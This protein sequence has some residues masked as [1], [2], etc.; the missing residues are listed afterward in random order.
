VIG[1]LF[2]GLGR[3]VALVTKLVLTALAMVYL[4][5]ARSFLYVLTAYVAVYFLAGS[6]LVKDVVQDLVSKEIPGFVTTGTIQLGP[7][8]WALSLCDARVH[9]EQS[10]EVMRIELLETEVDWVSMATALPRLLLVPDAPIPM[11]FR[12]VRIVNPMIHVTMDENGDLDIIRAF[13]IPTGEPS[14]P[15]PK[16]IR[17]SHGVLVGGR[18]RVD[19]P[20]V[21]L[22]AEG[23]NLN[24]ANFLLEDI[25]DVT[26]LIPKAQI[27]V[28]DFHMRPHFR[29]FPSLSRLTMPIRN[30]AI[31]RF[32]FVL[33]HFEAMRLT[34]DLDGGTM[35]ASMAM[36]FV[37]GQTPLWKGRV[38]LD[39]PAT[40]S[41]LPELFDGF[42]SGP[43]AAD[44]HGHGSLSEVNL[45]VA[46]R[47]PSMVVG[48]HPVEGV[49]IEASVAPEITPEGR[50]NHP[51][52]LHRFVGEM[53]GGR[54]DVGPFRYVMRWAEPAAP[55]ALGLPMPGLG[56]RH[57]FGGRVVLEGIDPWALLEPLDLTFGLDIAPFLRGSTSGVVHTTGFFDE[58]TGRLSV[59]GSTDKLTLSWAR[60]AGWPLGKEFE[61]SGGFEFSQGGVGAEAPVGSTFED[62]STLTLDEVRVKSGGDAIVVDADFDLKR[63]MVDAY[64]DMRIRDLRRFL[65]HFGVDEVSGRARLAR[66]RVVGSLWDPS[67]ETHATVTG[68]GLGGNPMGT[69]SARLSI[70]EGLLSVGGLRTQAP[71]GSASANGRIRLWGDRIDEPHPTL[72]FTVTDARVDNLQLRNLLPKIGMSARVSVLADRITGEAARL[73]DTIEGAGTV[74]AT[75]VRLGPDSARLV[76]AQLVA[77]ARMLKADN[78]AIT[79]A[80]GDILRGSVMMTKGGRQFSAQLKTESLP[81]TAI[82]WFAA[83][84]VDLEGQVTADLSVD[85]TL[86]DPVLIGTVAATDFGLAPIHFGDGTFSVTTGQDGR[87]EL[88]ALEDF[89][90]TTMLEGSHFTIERGVPNYAN[91][92]VHAEDARVYEILPFLQI[93]G[94]EL[95]GSGLVEVEL[96]PG[97]EGDGWRLVVDAVPGDVRL[98][99]FDGEMAYDNL[100]EVF[101]VMTP[102]GLTIEPVALGRSLDDAV[103]VCGRLDPETL[104]DLQVGGRVNLGV[105]RFLKD[106]FSVMEGHVV[107]SADPPTAAALGDLACLPDAGDRVMRLQGELLSPALSGSLATDDVLLTPRNFGR[108]IE[109]LDGSKVL[110]RPGAAPGT[111]RLV[112][113]GARA[114]RVRG[115]IEDGQ[116]EIWGEMGLKDLLLD[117][118]ELRVAGTEIF[119]PSPGEFNITF[120]PEI[121]LSAKSFMNDDQR[122]LHL[123]GKAQITE[124]TYYRSFDT[125]GQAL[126]NLGGSGGKTHELPLVE[127]VPWLKDLT[128]D[129]NVFGNTFEVTSPYTGGS[130]AVD[131]RFDLR[132]S[133]T[134]EDLKIFDRLEVIPGG[135]VT[136]EL[137]GR[138]FEV[139]RGTVDFRGSVDAPELDLELATDV[140]Y[141][142]DTG[143]D[144]QIEERVVTV[145]VGISGVPPNLD[146]EFWSKDTLGFDQADLQSLILTGSP[147]DES[148]S[149]QD[150]LGISFDFS[151]F[152][153]GVL[154]APFFEAFKARVGPQGTVTTKI[155][156]EFG[157]AVQLH[158]KVTQAAS[159]TRV[160]AGFQFQLSDNLSLEGT[161]QRTDHAQN[162]TQTYEAR[163][164]YRIPID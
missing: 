39:L 51:F 24:L 86:A 105:L 33:N 111:Q 81:L 30:L 20:E 32:Q 160:R 131:T 68:A 127:R 93:P 35:N 9:G 23:I 4:L 103:T 148:T 97:R 60:L 88:S 126:V 102:R 101:L 123:A 73:V 19:L 44:V 149:L 121:T 138:E 112:V 77:N 130:A 137:I 48:G 114:S 12:N 106:L 62:H 92:R 100:S 119:H 154:K 116:F 143:V 85:G 49:D 42:V 104:W 109:V 99:L 36:D 18:M 65:G 94:T 43:M 47:S 80:S 8:P 52:T 61:V 3:A 118:A 158:T 115:K 162:P 91:L 11:L 56:T 17:I 25:D 107:V 98:S 135:T 133:G 159:E 2:R 82:K 21:R 72:P 69:V 75:D 45:T 122:K 70:R 16:R 145:S 90:G 141:E 15:P 54:V 76:T 153:S 6:A 125:L 136:Y 83:Q 5:V 87:V 7:M 59:D 78:V 64:A 157:R 14:N 50:I 155:V 79:L 117:S 38:A 66:V 29:P 84:G 150:S 146:I 128:L 22:D 41:I 71:W 57:A 53:F 46:A 132:V 13:N 144:D 37:R 89:P 161:L 28:L 151:E 67:I 134:L 142:V 95:V 63:E 1:R 40:S 58:E 129:L 140:I 147:R 139:I 113:D 31:T 26:F 108:E 74:R 34:G 124:G 27:D 156:T 110:V 164:K 120:N 10:Q 96:W 152:L 163:F 55:N